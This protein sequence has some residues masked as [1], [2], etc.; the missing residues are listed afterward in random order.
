MFGEVKEI[1]STAELARPFGLDLDRENNCLYVCSYDSGKIFR[2]NLN[3]NSSD[4]VLDS[5][6]PY[7]GGKFLYIFYLI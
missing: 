6:D 1:I 4:V 2:I 7:V 3:D 5:A